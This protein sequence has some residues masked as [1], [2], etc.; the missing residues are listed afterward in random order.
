MLFFLLMIRKDSKL[1]CFTPYYTE[2]ITLRP[3]TKTLYHLTK[4]FSIN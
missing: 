3:F 2:F 1:I 4:T